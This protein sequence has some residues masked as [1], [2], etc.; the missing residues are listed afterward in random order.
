MS[1]S[2]IPEYPPTGLEVIVIGAG[3][4]GLTAAIECARKGHKV[5][6]LERSPKWSQLGD[7]ISIS[8]FS[9]PSFP[10]FFLHD[11][12]ANISLRS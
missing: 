12:Y 3:F 5:Q 9:L 8:T 11:R 1:G 7:I 6:I 10:L 2:L 4:G